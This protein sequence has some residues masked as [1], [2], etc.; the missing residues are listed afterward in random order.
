MAVVRV[1]KTRNY[2]V[3]SNVH[4]FDKNISLKARGL[5][6]TVFALPDNWDYS[7]SGLVTLCKES[8]TA[9]KSCMNEL[10][11]H[12]YLRVT[13]ERGEKGLFEYIYTFY[14]NPSL[15]NPHMEEPMTDNPPMENP[16]MDNLGVE[17]PEVENVGL[18]NTNISNTKVSNTK[19]LN[20][21][22]S[23][24]RVAEPITRFE[25]FW[26]AYPKQTHRFLTEQE[27]VQSVCR[28]NEE[29]WLVEAAKEYALCVQGKDTKY[30]KNPEN[31]LKEN[32]YLDYPPGTY[33]KQ[34]EKQA[35]Q[36]KATGTYGYQKQKEENPKPK[37]NYSHL[38]SNYDDDDLDE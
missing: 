25:D 11:E 21:K 30:I 34:K 19:K 36:S 9:V 26:K 4:L 3:M 10:K 37:R 1:N 18:L 13:K 5:L 29:E 23:N 22:Q 7:I 15:D 20:T 8:E 14:E 12:G 31:W 32:L 17:S 35:E 33:E 16:P 38:I 2:T 24:S 6:S 28:G 27:Y